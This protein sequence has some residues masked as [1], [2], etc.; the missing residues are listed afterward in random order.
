[1]VDNK[2]EGKFQNNKFGELLKQ[3][4]EKRRLIQNYST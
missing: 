1:M 4:Q 2:A 3:C